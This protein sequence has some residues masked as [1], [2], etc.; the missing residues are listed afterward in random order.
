MWDGGE[1]KGRG[2]RAEGRI[3]KDEDETERTKGPVTVK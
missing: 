3:G 1:G 2:M